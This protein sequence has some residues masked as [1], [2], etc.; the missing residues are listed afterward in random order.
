MH[1]QIKLK[2]TDKVLFEGEYNSTK[3]TV[4]DAVRKGANLEG[5]DLRRANLIGADLRR[6]NLEGAN[7]TEANLEGANLT[8]AY[9]RRANLIGANLIGADLRRADLTEAY[10]RRANLIGAD[11]RRANLIGANLIGADLIGADLIGADL[12]RAN[13]IGADLI[14]AYLRGAN[15]IGAN[16]EGADLRRANLIGANL[17]GAD[18]EGANLEV[19]KKDFFEKLLVAKN[20]VTGLYNWL[21]EGK[22]NGSYY[23]GECACLVGSIAKIRNE[24]YK[25]MSIALKPDS[26]S[27]SERWFLAISEGDTPENNLISKI[28]KDWMEEFM[29]AHNV[30]M[31][32][33]NDSEA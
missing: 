7:L 19:I 6:A 21:L 24:N 3:E 5:A 32:S 25:K 15:L 2:F 20:E 28:T 26:T 4:E 11:L 14:G 17:I 23:E 18:L 1:F 31:P 10:L 22:I 33:L 9:L 16:L 12:R 27:A 8:E 13:L 30:P 29:K